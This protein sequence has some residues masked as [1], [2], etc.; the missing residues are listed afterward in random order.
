M[1]YCVGIDVGG[2]NIAFG[3]VDENYNIVASS[4]IK[5]LSNRGFNPVIDDI[6]YA[7]NSIIS[8][9]KINPNDFLA[10]GIGCPGAINPTTGV[11][12]YANNLDWYNVPLVDLIKSNLNYD[13]PIFV[14]N[15]ANAH[16]LGEHFAGAAKGS[17]ISITVTLGTG[18]G[19]GIIIDDKLFTGSNFAGAELGHMVIAID[20]KPCTCGRKGC[21]EAY[22]SV[23]GLKSMTALYMNID[24]NS[25]MWDL[26]DNNVSN[27]SGRTPYDAF[28]KGDHAAAATLSD[29]H[30]HLAAG[31]TNIINAFQPDTLVIGGGISNE[32]DNLLNPVREIISNEVYTRDGDKNTNI[33][34]AKLGNSAGIIGSS[35]PGFRQ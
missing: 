27:I 31:L 2:T 23:T 30:N 16:A 24:K 13:L 3:I 4:S 21:F 29:F 26:C 25:L 18:V 15:D 8:E 19:A 11:V 10:I 22:A 1:K 12:E 5:T 9:S 28:K 6:T 32:G 20:G 14:N 35:L 17:K 33:V 34:V 7:I